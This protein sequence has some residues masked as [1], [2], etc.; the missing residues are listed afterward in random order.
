MEYTPGPWYVRQDREFYQYNQAQPFCIATAPEGTDEDDDEETLWIVRCM[1][2]WDE[3]MKANAHLIASAPEMLS[4]LED[5]LHQMGTDFDLET[6]SAA[7][8][9]YWSYVR[10]MRE[11][12]AKATGGAA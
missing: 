3:E 8:Q 10:R 2:S 12:I 1:D 5:L 11:T 6:V 4:L 7:D 9:T